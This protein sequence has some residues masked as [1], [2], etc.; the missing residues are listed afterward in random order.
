MQQS[1]AEVDACGAFFLG[2]GDE[3][4]RL[5]G[6]EEHLRH[7]G[8]VAVDDDVDLVGLEY[9]HIDRVGRG[10]GGAEEDVRDLGRDHRS[11]PPVGEGVPE[12]VKQQA[13][14]AVVHAHVGAVHHLRGLAVD[15]TG[16][17][18]RLPPEFPALGRRPGNQGELLFARPEIAHHGVGQGACDLQR[19]LPVGFDPVLRGH[20]PELFFVGDAVPRG[21]ACGHLGQHLHQVPAVVGMGR[22]AR[23]HHPPQVSGDDDIGVGAADPLLGAFPEGVHPAGPHV[24]DAAAQPHFTV[25][26]LGRLSLVAVPHGFDPV[27]LG[28]FQHQPSVLGDGPV[29]SIPEHI[30]LPSWKSL[31][32]EGVGSADL[33]VSAGRSG[34]AL[35][36]PEQGKPRRERFAA[37]VPGYRPRHL[38]RLSMLGRGHLLEGQGAGLA[39][40]D[41]GGNSGPGAALL[42]S[43]RI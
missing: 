15:P 25:S 9:A 40:L 12:G 5:A 26:A 41:T 39:D 42:R 32:K 33:S 29:F 28:L 10:L 2:Q 1:P 16:H 18:P 23:G 31:L 24:A 11:A 3:V 7:H 13:L 27:L 6:L 22:R 4:R 38:A 36:R 37:G 34:S 20:P 30:G 14:P 17:D 19:R 21:P 8:V 43:C 35:R